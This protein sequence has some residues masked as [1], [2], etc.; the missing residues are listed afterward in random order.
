MLVEIEGR[1]SEVECRQR[2]TRMTGPR[3]GL[4]QPVVLVPC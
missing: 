3:Q 2:D 1:L 4:H